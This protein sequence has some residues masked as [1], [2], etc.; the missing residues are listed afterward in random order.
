MA[1]EPM[2]PKELLAAKQAAIT[3]PKTIR[4]IIEENDAIPPTGLFNGLNGRGYVVQAGVE[5]NVPA[6]LIEI[7][8]NAKFD[9]PVIDPMTRRVT[10]T[11]RRSRFS[12]RV[13]QKEAA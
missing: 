4:I 12:Y 1:N 5:V 6:A 3:A 10:G 9:A 8:D 7:L 11:S 13:I 2:T